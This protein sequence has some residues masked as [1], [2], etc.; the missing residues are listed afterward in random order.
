MSLS[1]DE[2][3]CKLITKILFAASQNEVERFCDAAM[4]GLE[5]HKVNEHIIARFVDKVIN[6]LE[7]FNPM[8]KNAQQWSNILVAKI[9]F[10]RIKRRINTPAN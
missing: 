2:Y 7:Q 1:L 10:K 6:E 8:K 9:L 5:H 4:K 3:R